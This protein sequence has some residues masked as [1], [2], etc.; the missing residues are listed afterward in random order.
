M[1]AP[2]IEL[3]ATRGVVVR[4]GFRV[5]TSETALHIGDTTKAQQDPCMACLPGRANKILAWH[6]YR[7]ER[8]TRSPRREIRPG[9][10]E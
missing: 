8:E 10:G 5:T 7:G 1:R 9:E 4:A 2:E 6:A 3:A